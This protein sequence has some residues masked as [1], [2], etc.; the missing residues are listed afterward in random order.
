[1]ELDASASGAPNQLPPPAAPTEPAEAPEPS[2]AELR[3][4][5]RKVLFE[6]RN[7]EEAPESELDENGEP[8]K[9]PATEPAP[10]E[11]KKD[12]TSRDAEFSVEGTR[13]KII[14]VLKTLSPEQ[15]DEVLGTTDDAFAAITGQRRELRKAIQGFNKQAEAFE[16]EKTEHTRLKSEWDSALVEGKQDPE[17][18][19]A[20]FGWTL[21]DANNFFLEGKTLPPE[22]KY[23]DLEERIKQTLEERL[24][25][26][27]EA[28]RQQ[29]EEIARERTR[30]NEQA[31][32]NG[33]KSELASADKAEF[34]LTT[35]WPSEEIFDA[36]I[37]LQ[38]MHMQSTKKPLATKDALV[39]IEDRLRLQKKYLLGDGEVVRED[40]KTSEA[41]KGQSVV[42]TPSARDASERVA[43]GDDEDE[44][45]KVAMKKAKAALRGE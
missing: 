9:P 23:A 43:D 25:P 7:E 41:D 22:K 8:V 33:V 2:D 29:K 6:S 12:A 20:L 13:A 28:I 1:M 37:T 14:E 21:E 5:A 30:L 26:Q 35:R 3:E 42:R 38:R 16:A 18:A 17:K 36:V 44:D 11:E 31:W 10:A 34:P 45:P 27:E 39:H 32:H 15:R 19:L 4:Q 24:K 40:R